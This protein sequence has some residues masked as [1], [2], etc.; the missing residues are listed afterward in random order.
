[1]NAWSDSWYGDILAIAE[2]LVSL[3]AG[4][5]LFIISLLERKRTVQ[6]SLTV[7]A[8]LAVSLLRD[9]VELRLSSDCRRIYNC[10]FV[11]LRAG[12]EAIWLIW[13]C[14]VNSSID[15]EKDSSSEDTASIFSRVFFWWINPVLKAGYKSNLSLHNLPDIHRS[16][17]S[18]TLRKEALKSWN[19]QS[20][21]LTQWTLPLSLVRGLKSAFLTPVISRLFVVLFRYAQPIL[22][23]VA[24]RFVRT[25]H[26][27]EADMH[28]GLWLITF[29]GVV[30]LGL[31]ISTAV[32]QHQIDR[33]EIMVRGAL[34]G[35]IHHQSLNAPSTGSEDTQ[36]LA[37]LTSDI[38][39]IESI[40]GIFHETWAH[41]LEVVVGTALLAAR[42]RWFAFLPLLIIF[43]CSRVSAY[44][45]KHLQGKQRDWNVATQERISTTSS[46]LGGIK[47]VKMMGLEDPIHSQISHLRD[48][49]LRMSKRLRWIQVAYNASANALGIFAPVL[50]LVVYAMSPQNNG[51]L[52]P[53]EVFTSVALLAMV[54]HPAN[55]VMTFISR[56]VAMM[57][58]INRVQSYISRPSLEDTRETLVEEDVKESV[59][60]ENV[61][62]KPPSMAQPI[63]QGACLH[64]EK[65]DLVIVGGAV[66]S[67]KTTVALAMLGEV[68]LTT[69]S[70]CVASKRI[71][72][73]SQAP[74]LPSVTIRDAICGGEVGDQEWY[75]TVIDACGLVPDLAVLSSGDMT[76]IEN[77]GINISGGQR[78][79]IALARAVFSRYSIILLDDPFSALDQAVTDGI[80][81]KLLGSQ[82]LFKSMR[83]TVLLISNSRNL[84][85]MAD[86][87]LVIRDS[88]AHLEDLISFEKIS[89]LREAS[90]PADTSPCATPLYGQQQKQ[91]S[92]KHRME[93]A[94]EDISRRAGDVA[95]YGYYLNAVG[96]CNALLMTICTA[97]YSFCFTFSQYVLKWAT[98]APPQNARIYM[99]CYA[100]ISFI[101]WV[102]TNGNMWSTQLK[103]AIRS[104]KVLHAQLLQ[105]ILGASLTYFI[106][107][108]IAVTLNRFGQDITLIDKQ[109]PSALANLLNTE[110]CKLLM[111]VLLLLIVQPVMVA[112]VP[113]CAIC[114]YFI[115]RVYLRTSRQLRFLDLE[116]RSQLYTN[117]L[118]TSSGVTTIRAFGWKDKFQEE[119]IKALDL[120]QKPFYLLLC[121]QR[122]LNVT[123]DCVIAVIAVALMTLTVLYRNTTTGADL[124][125]ALNMI[126]GVNA[127]L[128][129]LVQSWTSLETSLG[130]I[131]RLKS[132]QEC[133]PIEDRPWGT[134]EPALQWPSSG[135]LQIQNASVSYSQTQGL[136]LED[137]SLSVNPGQKLIVVGRTGSGK[138]TLM[139]PLLQL[140][141]PRSGSIRIDEVDITR[142]P[143]NTLRRRGMIAVP[144][145]GFI[146]PTASLRFNLDPYG[147]SS[148]DTILAALK[149]TRL[150][151]KISTTFAHT[152]GP[153]ADLVIDFP[154]LLDL[155]MSTFLPFSA[156]ELQLFALCRTLLRVWENKSTKPVIVLDEAGSSLDSET[157]SILEEILREDLGGHTV[158]IIAHRVEGVMG[159]MRPG[160]DA[161]ATMQ[162]G[163]LQKVVTIASQPL[164]EI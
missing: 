117:F 64:L 160:V 161:I 69:G 21:T 121:L 58:N 67:G 20:R 136:T 19:S 5:G 98:Q 87:V 159:A 36:A 102:A 32:Y 24:I 75:N 122:W 33:L 51:V 9:A 84:Y 119:N 153:T 129:K 22:I 85:S 88:N 155:P 149:R 138:T 113:V 11:K 17:S 35:L 40:G 96:P 26:P 44:V 163:C 65:G 114:V 53:N 12:L 27:E 79:R 72:Y 124:G 100:A 60:M 16:L 3:Y 31:A 105:R 90:S 1:M 150:W 147:L 46:A 112:T 47:S 130:A 62:I 89:D 18:E 154:K 30:Y 77:N 38:E 162:N 164:L 71:A 13:N 125:L 123:L 120:S 118:D 10:N 48:Q 128:L 45:A 29:A 157:E 42:I 134:I 152:A 50:T 140:L 39:S 63:I 101:A 158:V 28:D 156:G 70:I 104:G 135:K 6:P 106:E 8:F 99:G 93:D 145:D 43:G 143:L 25:S 139:L 59:A 74:W 56:A 80:V 55:M 76:F 78:Q 7:T 111:Q 23:D 83:T 109:L 37:L 52:Q 131:A 127:T 49:E 41:F 103:I 14:G 116:S 4:V 92:Q 2:V 95:L 132:V 97:T 142:V 148:E 94:A 34:I 144:Q 151:N 73:C 108:D 115:Q 137:I 66:G 86:R 126:I 81:N 141:T 133:V 82:G 68:P 110:I 91:S 57:A 107:S 146:I 54:T 15:H 61:T